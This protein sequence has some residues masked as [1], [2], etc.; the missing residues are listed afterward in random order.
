L[1]PPAL[2]RGLA[3]S[4]PVFSESLKIACIPYLGKIA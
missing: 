3:R 4:L 1:I 2:P